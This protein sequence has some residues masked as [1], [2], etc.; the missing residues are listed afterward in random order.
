MIPARAVHELAIN[1]PGFG[2]CDYATCPLL[3]RLFAIS[4]S[5]FRNQFVRRCECGTESSSG[6]SG[7]PRRRPGASGRSTRTGRTGPQR[8]R[9]RAGPA[10]IGSAP[11][12]HGTGRERAGRRD[13]GRRADD[14]PAGA[15][16]AAMR[17][18]AARGHGR[19]GRRRG[20]PAGPADAAIPRRRGAGRHG[21]S[22][23]LRR[24]ARDGLVGDDGADARPGAAGEVAAARARGRR[25][26]H[27]QRAGDERDQGG[28]RR[29]PAR[30][31]PRALR[32]ARGDPPVPVP[33]RR[34]RAHRGLGSPAGAAEAAHGAAG[35]RGRPG[36]AAGRVPRHE[37]GH[38]LAE[39]RREDRVRGRTARRAAG[40]GRGRRRR[41][42][43]AVRL[44]GRDT[45]APRVTSAGRLRVVTAPAGSGRART[46]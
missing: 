28:R 34:R 3:G 22:H 44:G 32:P 30:A 6:R 27:R 14:V 37:L 1:R 45:G 39:D 43:P 41:T 2:N 5:R 18:H 25:R 13:G 9:R 24:A 29:T 31:V 46:R 16:R 10:R 15:V 20:G 7:R 21:R 40:R 35:G 33:A 12:G 8:T 26:A 19:A 4:S 11:P 23:E 42:R 17:R 36:A 38:P